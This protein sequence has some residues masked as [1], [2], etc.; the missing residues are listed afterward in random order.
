MVKVKNLALGH[1]YGPTEPCNA[2]NC[3]CCEMTTNQESFTINN[4]LVKSAPGNCKSYNVIYMVTCTLCDLAYVGRTT[5]FLRS[6][7]QE[8]RASYYNIL[9]GNKIDPLNDNFSL[10]LHLTEHGLL[11]RD[12]FNKHFRVC[13]IDNSSTRNIDIKEHK[14][15]HILNTLRPNGINTLNPFG[16][17]LLNLS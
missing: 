10:G 11:E 15:I 7:I 1:K 5:R 9:K 12:G 2:K 3:K 17:P 4:K 13:I 14:F 16:I 8:H 6:R